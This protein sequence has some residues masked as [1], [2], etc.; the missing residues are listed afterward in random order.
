MISNIKKISSW[1]LFA[2]LC[3]SQQALFTSCSDDDSSGGGVPEITGVRSCDPTKA[4][5][6][7]TKASPGQVI[8]IIGHNLN[9][10]LKVYINDQPVYF[11]PNM[12]TDHSIIVNVPTEKN[13]FKLT[14]F[15]SDLKDEIRVETTHGTC[16]YSFK[17]SAGYPILQRIAASY[18]R[19][20]GDEINVYGLN[21]T[22]IENAYFTSMTV[23]EIEALEGKEIGGTKVPISGLQVVKKERGINSMTNAYETQSQ[24]RFNLPDLPFTEGTLVIETAGGT[25][26]I[27]YSKTPG[28]PVIFYVSNDM[29]QIGETLII[30][31][32]EFVQVESVK[33]GDVT[34][35][36]SEFRVSESEDSIYVNFAQKPSVGSET[37]LT[38]TTPGGEVSVERF[39]DH[40][41][42]LTTFD[43]DATD[44]G[45]SPNAS[46][47]DSGTA[48]GQYAYIYVPEE[49]QQWWGTMI[50]FR[51]DWSGNSFP[52]SD[53]IPETATADEVYF[54][55]N[56]FSESDYNNGS[57]WGYIRY[58]FQP[59]GDAENQYDNHIGWENYDEQI[60]Q[61][62][63]PVLAD[64]NNQ[65]PTGKWYRHVLPLSKFACYQGKTYAEIKSIGLNQFRLQSI[66]Q[67]T[68]R[69]KVDVKFDNCRV[70]YIPNK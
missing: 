38:V 48:D 60:A 27:P 22:D 62:E 1:I 23:E 14:A 36:E 30:T 28:Q 21:L 35:N 39:Y 53:N 58:M 68:T 51:K 46:Y 56:V 63:Q 13:G 61:F 5:S 32:R 20:T 69:G 47:V 8:A 43:G 65:A 4:D 55:T 17:I 9:D 26:Y 64:I 24:L 42:I 66:N 6:L 37:T 59:I 52:L 7:F 11:N 19:E 16:T 40:S 34:L 18:P 49:G 45:W 57:F 29:P 10:A 33:Y 54:A 67:S 12:N 41:T 44:N 2:V 50:Y 25:A 70:I 15:N 31:G 3:I